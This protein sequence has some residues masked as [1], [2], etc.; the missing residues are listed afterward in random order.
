MA[1]NT[2]LASGLGASRES[3]VQSLGDQF[4]KSIARHRH[5]EREPAL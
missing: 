4:V 5:L 3:Y 1:N 2:L